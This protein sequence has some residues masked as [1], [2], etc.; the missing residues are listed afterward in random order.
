MKES[1]IAG[2]LISTNGRKS[3]LSGRFA[4]MSSESQPAGDCEKIVRVER[5]KTASS[6][7]H[8]AMTG[9]RSGVARGR[10]GFRSPREV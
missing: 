7:G 6:G 3:L 2:N 8:E 1:W 4:G 10:S 5:W 9:E